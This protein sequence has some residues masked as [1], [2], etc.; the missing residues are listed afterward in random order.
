TQLSEVFSVQ[1]EWLRYPFLVY[2]PQLLRHGDMYIDKTE[3]FETARNLLA[4]Q[5][6]HAASWEVFMTKLGSHYSPMPLRIAHRHAFYHRNQKEG[7]SINQFMSAL[8]TAALY[9]EFINLDDALLDKLD[10]GL[11]DLHL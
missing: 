2:S 4:P 3:V 10:C 1:R 6:I 5:K 9:C 11:R 7:E 8:R